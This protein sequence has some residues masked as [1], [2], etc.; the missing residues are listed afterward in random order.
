MDCSTFAL[1]LHVLA[2]PPAFN[3]SQDQTLQLIVFCR[4]RRCGVLS[5]KRGALATTHSRAGN[6][7]SVT[8][9]QRSGANRRLTCWNFSNILSSV[10]EA[11][12]SGGDTILVELMVSDI[13][14][15]FD[16]SIGL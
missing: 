16:R 2:M 10:Q 8:P 9:V 4:I 5:K 11:N 13:T 3:L 1:D 14:R 12:L 6:E 7:W 15:M